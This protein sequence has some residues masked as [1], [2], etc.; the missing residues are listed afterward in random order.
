MEA[1]CIV[2]FFCSIVSF[3][4]IANCQG[5]SGLNTF[6]ILKFCRLED[7]PESGLK[8]TCLQGWAAFP[9]VGDWG[10]ICFLASPPRPRLASSGCPPSLAQWCAFSIFKAIRRYISLTILLLAHLTLTLVSCL[11]LSL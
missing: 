4:G 5:F 10:E 1:I 6:I 3:A 2:F 7:L 11:P 8:S 9:V